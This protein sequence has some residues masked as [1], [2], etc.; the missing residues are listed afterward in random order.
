M[1]QGGGS[2]TSSSNSQTPMTES[3]L[4][5]EKKGVVNFVLKSLGLRCLWLLVRCSSEIALEERRGRIAAA[6]AYG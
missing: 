3:N 4:K 6:A 1:R 5:R 2:G